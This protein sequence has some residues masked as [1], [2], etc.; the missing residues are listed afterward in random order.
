MFSFPIDRVVN[1]SSAAG[2]LQYIP[3]KEVQ[4]KFLSVTTEEDLC[5]LMSQFVK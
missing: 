1:V 4:Q 3:S 2:Q 5:S